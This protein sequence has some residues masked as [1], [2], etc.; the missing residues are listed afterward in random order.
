[1][2]LRVK[3]YIHHIPPHP[4][5]T[6]VSPS[7]LF[8]VPW[9]P[10]CSLGWMLLDPG[11]CHAVPSADLLS[12]PFPVMLPPFYLRALGYDMLFPLL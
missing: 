7:V 12:C 2:T 6:S 5:D 3:P 1:M 10:L 8:H 9:R 4:G 11:M